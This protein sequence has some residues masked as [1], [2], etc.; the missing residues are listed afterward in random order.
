MR[1]L[2]IVR[3]LGSEE[4]A[5]G[6]VKNIIDSFPNSG[7]SGGTVQDIVNYILYAAGILAVVMI[8]VAGIKM[9][10]SGGNPGAVAKAKQ[11]LVYAII[12]LAV[13]ILA[14]AIVN[15]VVGKL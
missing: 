1:F 6:Q 4:S 11:T 12:G 7:E 2:P 5:K 14:Y 8:I 10:T 13:V 3:V 15:F 9:T